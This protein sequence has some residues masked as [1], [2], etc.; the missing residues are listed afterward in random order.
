MTRGA[1]GVGL[2]SSALL[3]MTTLGCGDDALR[4][5][6]PGVSV[7]PAFVDFGSTAVLEPA[8]RQVTVYN[9]GKAPLSLLEINSPAFI[10]VEGEL[11]LVLE[12]G[13]SKTL[14]ARFTP[15]SEMQ[16]EG[17]LE[18]RFDDD[19]IAQGGVV[20]RRAIGER[21]DR[22]DARRRHQQASVGVIAS[23]DAHP[24]LEALE[25]AQQDRVR[26]Q[27]R[28]GDDLQGR[29]LAN[30]L[31]DPSGKAVRRRRTYLEPEAAQRAA[32]AHLDVVE[33]RLHQLAR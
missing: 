21:Y 9:Q 14:W 31:P 32:K 7:A 33:L 6:V 27:Q 15:Q 10:V 24:L 12:G 11:P 3:L 4:K 29:M 20:D 19:G 8:S 22:S 16:V 26:R 17:S 2:L 5:S 25:L 13:G 28:L 18:L 1:A 23:H 30:Q